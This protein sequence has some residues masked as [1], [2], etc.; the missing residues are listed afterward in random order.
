MIVTVFRTRVRDDADLDVMLSM[1][2]RMYEI[3]ASMPGFVS[4]KE[5]AAED[6]EFV[7]IVE[8]ESHETLRAWREHPE[9]V[10]AQQL[11]RSKF[12]LDYHI[13]VCEPVREYSFHFEESAAADGSLKVEH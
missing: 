9:H 5:F 4:Y 10:H 3:A 13:Q 12:F 8:F 1:G 11:G 2:G 7:A 6:G